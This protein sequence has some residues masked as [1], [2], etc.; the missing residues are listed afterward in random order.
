MFSSRGR[1]VFINGD[2]IRFFKSPQKS[3]C[4]DVRPT[5]KDNMFKKGKVC[6]TEGNKGEM[7]TGT[8]SIY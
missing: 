5:I 6:Q 3:F 1:S 7:I 2:I 4:S 8:K